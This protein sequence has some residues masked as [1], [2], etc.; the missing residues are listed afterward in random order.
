[1]AEC[2]PRPFG[3]SEEIGGV[4]LPCRR[5]FPGGRESLQSV[6]PDRRQHAEPGLV[7]VA[8][9]PPQQALVHQGRDEV[10]GRRGAKGG[11]TLRGAAVRGLRES[12]RNRLLVVLT[13]LFP[14]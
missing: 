3:E 12:R 9:Q 6:L 4:R 5:F 11:A 2:G 13:P 10:E 1:M 7:A 8:V 14:P